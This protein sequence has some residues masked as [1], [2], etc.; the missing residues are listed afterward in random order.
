ML[1]V[2]QLRLLSPSQSQC[3]DCRLSACCFNNSLQLLTGSA[4]GRL[5]CQNVCLC[6][7]CRDKEKGNVPHIVCC[8][9]L[10]VNQ[11]GEHSLYGCWFLH[12]SETFHLATRKFLQKVCKLRLCVLTAA[13]VILCRVICVRMCISQLLQFCQHVKYSNIYTLLSVLAFSGFTFH[14]AQNLSSIFILASQGSAAQ[15]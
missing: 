8:E 5:V 6:V 11:D 2:T 4:T 12:P 7:C 3:A 1:Q 10:T 13:A 15:L 14:Q 9:Q